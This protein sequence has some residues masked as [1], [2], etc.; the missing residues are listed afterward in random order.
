MDLQAEGQCFACGAA[1]PIGLKLKFEFEDDRY[2]ARF[3]PASH[4]Q[5]YD[6]I[7]HGGI[8]STLLDEAMAKLVWAKGINA[9]TG[10]LCVRFRKPA[11]TG[12]ELAVS[13]WI[14]SEAHRIIDCRAELRNLRGELLANATGRMVRV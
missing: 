3:I 2:V 14:V 11:P 12:E 13:G 4:F 6:G 8:V 1:N 9:V 5:G 7:T 10:E